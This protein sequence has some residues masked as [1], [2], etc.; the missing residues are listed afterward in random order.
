M[1]AA[2]SDAD[3]VGGGAGEAGG[4]LGQ[5]ALGGRRG[6]RAADAED[7]GSS[8]TRLASVKQERTRRAPAGGVSTS[9]SSWMAGRL[10]RV[11]SRRGSVS[12]VL[13]MVERVVMAGGSSSQE[14]AEA[15]AELML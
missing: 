12:S 2:I 6:E 15:G 10:W 5:G 3:D 1:T 9:G 13:C 7:T 8:V 14:A 4:V 11:S